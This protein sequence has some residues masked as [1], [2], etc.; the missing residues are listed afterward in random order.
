MGWSTSCQPRSHAKMGYIYDS[1]GENWPRLLFKW[2]TKM[3]EK[4]C[5]EVSER[6]LNELV[7]QNIYLGDPHPCRQ[8]GELDNF[9]AAV[10]QALTLETLVWSTSKSLSCSGITYH[11]KTHRKRRR[12]WFERPLHLTLLGLTDRVVQSKRLPI[13]YVEGTVNKQQRKWSST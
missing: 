1:I 6:L 2:Q 5:N 11:L 10:P 13:T 12:P 8:H 4:L 7:L 9:P 3:R